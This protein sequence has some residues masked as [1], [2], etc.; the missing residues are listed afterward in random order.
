MNQQGILDTSKPLDTRALIPFNYEQMDTDD[1]IELQRSIMHT[2]QI[3]ERSTTALNRE[4]TAIRLVLAGRERQA[5]Q[6]VAEG[7]TS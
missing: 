7:S 1:L 4:Y 3:N 6:P 2:I 5:A